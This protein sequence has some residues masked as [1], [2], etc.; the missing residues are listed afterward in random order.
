MVSMRA[1]GQ[2]GFALLVAIAV[3]ALLGM[4]VL[5]ASQWLQVRTLELRQEARQVA[6]VALGDA[7]LAEALAALAADPSCPGVGPHPFGGGVISARVAVGDD[8][9]RLVRASAR[10]GDAAGLV[11]ARVE[12]TPA[13][14]RVLG[15][16][17]SQGPAPARQTAP[18][19][20]L[21]TASV[22][23]G[24]RAGGGADS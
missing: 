7:A 16:R 5:A 8:R 4:A 18:A 21:S 15:W 13:G 12:L 23:R 22:E 14:P 3:T 1:R 10:L 2:G 20:E 11:E 6:L 19:A 17:R 9:H 24:Y